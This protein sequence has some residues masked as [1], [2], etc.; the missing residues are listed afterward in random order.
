MLDPILALAYAG[1]FLLLSFVLLRPDEGLFWQWQRQRQLT[2]RVLSEDALKHIYKNELINNVTTLDSVTGAIGI[3]GNQTA[4]LLHEMAKHG[5]LKLEGTEFK[6]TK[7]GRVSALHIL[8]AHRLW[9]HYLAEQTGF[10]ESEWHERAELHEHNM[11]LDDIDSLSNS[12]GNPTHDPHG[13]PI[14]TSS[15]DLVYHGGIPLSSQEI[16]KRLHIVHLEDEPKT[17]YSQLVAL[18]LHPGMEIQVLEIGQHFVRIWAAGDEHVIAPLLAS[19]ISVIP[20]S[21]PNLDD[22]AES[23]R[24]SNLDIGRS[25]R[26][27]RIS[28]QCRGLERRRLLDLG[29]LPG[30]VI[31]AEMRSPSGDPTAY[32]IREA[33]IGLRKEQ[34]SMISVV[35]L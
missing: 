21:E 30:T 12:L 27:M 31:K 7:R 11:T 8:R 1:L 29:V 6:L 9:E 23:E 19:N 33:L 22:M 18:G 20:V 13:D 15:G 5:L 25:C 26:V 24:L 34:A 35:P 4:I 10:V 16:G 14:P 17:L 3:S 32:R 2:H 28:R